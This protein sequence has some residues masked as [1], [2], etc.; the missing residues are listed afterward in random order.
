MIGIALLAV[1]L[2]SIYRYNQPTASVE[3]LPADYRTSAVA[4]YD[5]FA[6]N[7]A[8]ANAQYVD[9]VL[10]VSGVVEAVIRTDTT[11]IILLKSNSIAGGVSCNLPAGNAATASANSGDN[12]SIKGRCTGFLADVMLVD[13]V[14]EP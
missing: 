10:L 3:S 9:K 11:L 4:L 12:L 2:Y 14:L 8:A 13:C 6:N 5:A 1:A 7:E